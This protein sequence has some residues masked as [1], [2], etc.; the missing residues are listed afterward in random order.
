MYVLLE[1]NPSEC[2][3][4]WLI[5]QLNTAIFPNLNPVEK[6]SVNLKVASINQSIKLSYLHENNEGYTVI[7]LS[8][9]DKLCP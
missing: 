9:A 1:Y 5:D 3:T 2:L 8:F 6:Q 7:M 4:N